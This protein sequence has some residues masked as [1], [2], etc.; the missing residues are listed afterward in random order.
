MCLE[1]ERAPLS[2]ALHNN[3]NSNR[4][5]KRCVHHALYYGKRGEADCFRG[6]LNTGLLPVAIRSQFK[7]HLASDTDVVTKSNWDQQRAQGGRDTASVRPE[8]MFTC[9]SLRG[10]SRE[11]G[12]VEMNLK[13]TQALQDTEMHKPVSTRR[14]HSFFLFS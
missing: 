8:E 12:E 10:R 9:S 14:G 2:K 4:R 13:K 7:R 11:A 5:Q 3:R 6:K 1:V